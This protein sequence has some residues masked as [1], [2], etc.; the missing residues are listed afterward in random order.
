MASGGRTWA[1]WYT[2]G[3]EP[4]LPTSHLQVFYQYI[5]VLYARGAYSCYTLAVDLTSVCDPTL[6]SSYNYSPNDPQTGTCVCP[7][8]TPSCNSVD[9]WNQN[10]FNELDIQV[11][12]GG[13]WGDHRCRV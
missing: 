12:H 11:R 8:G 13:Q 6:Q 7:P 3:L 9:L 1:H 10:Q 5:D 2:L 4:R